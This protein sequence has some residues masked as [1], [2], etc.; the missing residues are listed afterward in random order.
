MKKR[1][2]LPLIGFVLFLSG[3]GVTRIGRILDEPN[4]YRN[5]PVTVEGRVDHSVGAL[6]A[7]VYQVND[8]TGKIYVISKA[9]VPRAG[10]NVKVHGR[11]SQGVT[12]GDR[13]FG[14]VLTEDS[15]KVRY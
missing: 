11:V 2:L 12:L 4:R 9:G 10:T 14:T 13:S 15:H 3:C 8:N 1:L 6:L 5:R 7:G